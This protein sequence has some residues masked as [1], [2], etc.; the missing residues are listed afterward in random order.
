MALRSDGA[1]S[2]TS[3]STAVPSPSSARGHLSAYYVVWPKDRDRR[4]RA[5]VAWLR[6]GPRLTD[7]AGLPATLTTDARERSAGRGNRRT[8]H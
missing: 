1:D 4:D 2:S 7:L 8:R 3:W 6:T 5:L